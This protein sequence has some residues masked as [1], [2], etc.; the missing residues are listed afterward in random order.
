MNDHIR[1]I[2]LNAYRR[3]GYPQDRTGWP[4]DRRSPLRPWQRLDWLKLCA[5]LL[6]VAV[7]LSF[8]ACLWLW[9]S[10]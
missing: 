6:A 9:M 2:D 3:H 5:W 10:A 7:G 8:W 1:D 4:Q